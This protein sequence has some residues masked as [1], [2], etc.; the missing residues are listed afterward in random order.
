MFHSF[1]EMMQCQYKWPTR[2]QEV[3]ESTM[4]EKLHKQPP[5]IHLITNHEWETVTW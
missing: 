4:Y 2:V 1:Q 5:V 3:A